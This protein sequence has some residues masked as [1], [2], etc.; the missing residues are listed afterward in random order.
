MNSPVIDITAGVVN[1]Q[2]IPVSAVIPGDQVFDTL[3][4][5][6][7]VTAIKVTGTKHL[8]HVS[9][10]TSAYPDLWEPWCFLDEEVTIIANL[11][12]R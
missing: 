3:G 10:K 5:P 12:A 11:E 6:K 1:A 7:T 2:R 4:H 9:I 8:P